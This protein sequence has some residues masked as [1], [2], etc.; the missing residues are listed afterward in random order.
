MTTAIEAKSA[1]SLRTVK[2]LDVLRNLL[3]QLLRE[4]CLLRL[5]G[6]NG[7]AAQSSRLR[8]IRREIARVKTVMHE[9]RG[10]Q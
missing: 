4:Q 6:V 3:K 9:K 7:Q 8:S 5:Q 2:D 1:Q 10:D